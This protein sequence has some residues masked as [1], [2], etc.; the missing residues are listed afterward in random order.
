[1][2]SAKRKISIAIGIPAHNEEKNIGSLLSDISRQKK[3]D[4]VL[5]KII[6]GADFCTDKTVTIVKSHNDGRIMCL[7]IKKQ[8][9]QAKTQNDIIDKSRSDYLIL[10]NA[11]IRLLDPYFLKKVTHRILDSKPDLLSTDLVDMESHTFFGSILHVSVFW[12]RKVFSL[13]KRGNNVFTCHGALRVFSKRMY[14]DFCFDQSVHEDADSYLFAKQNNYKYVYA[15][16]IKSYYRIPQTMKDHEKQSLR[17]FSGKDNLFRKYGTSVVRKEYTIPPFF[18]LI[19]LTYVF[20][21]YPFYVFLYVCVALFLWI[22]A[23]V[24]P[25]TNTDIWENSASTKLNIG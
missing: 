5:Q 23:K 7:R 3:G 16:D 25:I 19:P 6:V 4:Y 10:V 8:Q 9:G 2:N 20:V 24:R 17:F 21:R 22:K 12:K 15:D 14:S 18:M 13:Y 1:M 11:D